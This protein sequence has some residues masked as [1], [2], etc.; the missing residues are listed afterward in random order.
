MP[1]DL[2]PVRK[3]AHA[4]AGLPASLMGRSLNWLAFVVAIGLCAWT[5]SNGIFLL[6]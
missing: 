5:V 3:P 2:P 4:V 6:R 1:I